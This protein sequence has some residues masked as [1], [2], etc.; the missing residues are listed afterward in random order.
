MNEIKIN[1]RRITP[2]QK[3]FLR[4]AAFNYGGIIWRAALSILLIPVYVRHLPSE[5]WGV[6]A[7]CMALQGFL[8]L[9]DAGLA[10][11]LPRDIARAGASANL[12]ANTF[13]KFSRMYFFLACLVFGLGQITIPWLT[14][15]WLKLDGIAPSD[16]VFTL[17]LA[18][19]LFFFQFWNTVH[20]GYWNGMQQQ[21]RSNISQVVFA[22]LKHGGALLMVLLWSPSADSYLIAFSSGAAIEWLCNRRLIANHLPHPPYK[23]T[24]SELYATARSTVTLSLGVLLGI[25]VSQLDKLLLPGIVSIDN[26]GRYAAVAGLGLAFL[27]FQSPVVSAL[28]PRLAKELPVGATKSLHTLVLALI[29][30]NILPCL[31]AAATA[32]WLLHLWIHSPIIVSMGT[33]PLQLILLSIAVN[34]AYQIFYQQI[35]VFGDGRYVMCINACNV[36]VVAVFIAFT[37]PHLGIVAGG[38]GWLLGAC[39]QLTAGLIWVFFR[40]PRMIKTKTVS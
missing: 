19:V 12:C 29:A 7:F 1:I 37:A 6:V 3:V 14:S 16:L 24:F 36:I 26:Y 34:S 35:L 40:K 28:Y 10:Q 22:T 15:T 9:V 31:I 27:Q 5:Q 30:T 38:A 18:F 8:T 20:L 13:A 4:N 32:S 2:E 33:L 17:R 39:V 25:L 21:H 11:I 23:P